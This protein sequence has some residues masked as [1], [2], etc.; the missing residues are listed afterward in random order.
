MTEE[1]RKLFFQD[2]ARKRREKG[3]RTG[4][5]KIAVPSE[6]VGPLYD[7]WNGFVEV[8]GRQKATDYLLVL[9]RNGD[10]ALRSALEKRAACSS[11]SVTK[12]PRGKPGSPS[13]SSTGDHGSA[14]EDMN[15]SGEE[16]E[17]GGVKNSSRLRTESVS[18]A[19]ENEEP[20]KATC[21]TSG[22][23]LR[24]GATAWE[25]S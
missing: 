19:D 4:T 9:L 2:L 25:S 12:W 22:K 20:G 21:T 24:R 18:S 16:I 6:A 13:N 10:W 15:T 23:R 3:I 17:H 1:E 11:I 7:F 5:F 14:S 8:L